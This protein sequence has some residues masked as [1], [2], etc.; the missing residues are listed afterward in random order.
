M[1]KN[2]FLASVEILFID[3]DDKDEKRNT[4]VWLNKTDERDQK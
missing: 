1:W 2:C 3:F 4:V